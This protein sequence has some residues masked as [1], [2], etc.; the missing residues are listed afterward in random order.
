MNAM[1][2]DNGFRRGETLSFS[3]DGVTVRAHRGETVAA[4][5]MAAGMLGLRRSPRDGAARG[6]FCFMGVCQECA[7]HIEGALK[8]ACQ[9]P[10]S[11]GL[12]VELRGAV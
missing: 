4:A 7:V 12:V 8:R 5:L 11:Q 10:A 6:A 3:A 1:R 9:V 2:F